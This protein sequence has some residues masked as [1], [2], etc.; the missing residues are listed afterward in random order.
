MNASKTSIEWKR[1]LLIKMSANCS[2]V[3]TYRKKIRLSNLIR[4]KSQPDQHGEFV[5]RVSD[6]DCDIFFCS[7]EMTA[8]LTSKM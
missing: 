8:S 3:R 7:Y 4:S 1:A 6:W 2:L 5:A